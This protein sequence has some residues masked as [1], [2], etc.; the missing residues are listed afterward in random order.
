MEGG[1]QSPIRDKAELL[2][3]QTLLS[4]GYSHRS[5]KETR[6]DESWLNVYNYEALKNKHRTANIAAQP[7]DTSA[8]HDPLKNPVV[9]DAT[10]ESIFMEIADLEKHQKLGSDAAKLT[11]TLMQATSRESTSQDVKLGV[12]V[13]AD[14]LDASRKEMGGRKTYGIRDQ[15]KLIALKA[16]IDKDIIAGKINADHSKLAILALAR[17]YDPQSDDANYN[18]LLKLADIEKE[19]ELNDIIYLLLTNQLNDFYRINGSLTESKAQELRSSLIDYLLASTTVAQQTR[20]SEK[21]QAVID[22]KDSPDAEQ[23]AA[24]SDAL[25]VITAS[26]TYVIDQHIEYLVFEFFMDKLIRKIQKEAFDELGISHGQIVD[27]RKLG[28]AIELIMGSGKTSVVLLLLCALNSNGKMLNVVILPESLIASM[29]SELSSQLFRSFAKHIDVM[30]FGNDRKLT[31]ETTRIVKDRIDAARPAKRTIVTTNSSVQGLFLTLLALLD[32][33]ATDRPII[34]Q[35]DALREI[36]RTFKRDGV[37]TIDEVD[38]AFDVMRAQQIAT[39]QRIRIPE[40]LKDTVAS[41]YHLLATTP[42][43]H[44]KYKFPFLKYSAGV[45]LTEEQLVNFKTDVIAELLKT[46]EDGHSFLRGV[47]DLNA[48]FVELLKDDETKNKIKSYWQ[49]CTS[50]ARE[51]ALA[52]IAD[53]NLTDVVAI[54]ADELNITFPITVAQKVNIHYGPL[55]RP[56]KTNDQGEALTDYEDLL[57]EYEK[58]RFVAIPYHDGS[59][60]VRSRFA[61]SIEAVNY[62]IEKDLSLDNFETYVRLELDALKR[63]G[64][65]NPNFARRYHKL[66][67]NFAKKH[68]DDLTDGEIIQVTNALDDDAVGEKIKMIAAHALSMVTS[69]D[70]QLY[71]NSLI[72]EFLFALIDGFSGTLWN[73]KT[74]PDVFRLP[75]K[76]S[77]TS[78]YTMLLLLSFDSSVQGI[79]QGNLNHLVDQIYGDWLDPGSFIDDAGIL[80]AFCN[81]DVAAAFLKYAKGGVI[82]YDENNHIMIMEKDGKVI[83]LM[84]TNVPLSDQIA[85]WDKPH[86]T[87]SNLKL[88]SNM[89]ARMSVDKHTRLRGLEQGSWRLRGLGLGQRIDR[90]IVPINDFDT[91]EKKFTKS[92]GAN[93]DR[94]SPNDL[95]T[96]VILNQEEQLGMLKWRSFDNRLANKLVEQ[97]FADILN[98]SSHRPA[99][100]FNEARDLFTINNPKHLY[101][102]YGLPQE[103]TDRDTAI[104]QKVSVLKNEKSYATYNVDGKIDGLWKEVIDKSK[105]D[106][107]DFVS[108][109][110]SPLLGTELRIEVNLNVQTQTKTEMSTSTFDSLKQPPNEAV[111]NWNLARDQQRAHKSNYFDQHPMLVSMKEAAKRNGRMQQLF[112]SVSNDIFFSANFAPIHDMNFEFFNQHGKQLT[113]MLVVYNR[114]TSTY[115]VVLLDLNDAQEW[116]NFLLEDNGDAVDARDLQISLYDLLDNELSAQGV[117][118]MKAEMLKQDS[119]FLSLLVQAKFIAGITNYSDEEKMSLAQWIKS[120]DQPSTLREIFKSTILSYKDDTMKSYFTSFLSH[121]FGE[122][123]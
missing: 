53:D 44:Q 50:S 94:N 88:K 38:L 22:R 74:F 16:S 1:Y 64:S 97:T 92:T 86:T 23:R 89:P 17:A 12:R 110:R 106:L 30:L 111:K 35:T 13:F 36:F 107:P 75:L 116:K 72:Y 69:F 34:E 83:P 99:N 43:L 61:R 90:Y 65:G 26:R 57:G 85:F 81:R 112:N 42:G 84:Q 58:S 108:M 51:A 32:E 114:T 54:I 3:S 20:C 104:E 55:P 62:T 80:R 76:L 103:P 71:T 8:I 47:Y 91:I 48:A 10:I 122:S 5:R 11:H 46:S 4:L 120:S 77:D 73:D 2:L 118:E 28:K 9:D 60:L 101:L 78:P 82:F 87:G 52:A 67:G 63:L 123:L 119:S 15:H 109:P 96:Y 79:T 6:N 105:K 117:L 14:R 7:L 40:V 66:V 115:R 33:N 70:N 37:L 27:G 45:P 31:P 19:A 24:I 100:I 29:A 102:V 18:E 98:R 41:F 113:D 59:P 121:F 56:N 21:L 95:V 39:G 93:F 25:E 49:L 68:I